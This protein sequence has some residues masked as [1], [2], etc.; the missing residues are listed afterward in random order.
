MDGRLITTDSEK[1]LLDTINLCQRINLP[2][3]CLYLEFS[4]ISDLIKNKIENIVSSMSEAIADVEAI[5][6][7]CSDSD[8]FIVSRSITQKTLLRV[9]GILPKELAPAPEMELARIFEINMSGHYLS[10]IMSEKIEVIK[11][12]KARELEDAK[13]S[14][15]KSKLSTKNDIELDI[16]LNANLISSIQSRKIERKQ[17]SILLVEDDIFSK[18]LVTSALRQNYEVHGASNGREAILSAIKNAPDII[19][20]DINL[21][22]MSGIDVLKELFVI[23]HYS[24]VIMLSGNGSRDNVMKAIEGGAKGFVSKPFTMD[25]IQ[26]Y[27]DRCP[28]IIEKRSRRE[29]LNA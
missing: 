23:D 9:L 24:Y 29:L 14:D 13:S 11:R 22:D 1:A 7:V 16:A 6:Y 12:I 10:Q 17:P 8:V 20:L 25:K 15:E 19:F 27:I 3:R 18:H 26:Q 21:P 28:S 2:L 4:R 5:T